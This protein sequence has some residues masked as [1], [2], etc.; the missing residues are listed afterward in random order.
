M[1]PIFSPGGASIAYTAALRWAW[2]VPVMGGTPHP[3]FPD[4]S[5][6]TWMDN[7]R[8][9]FS[10]I[11]SGRHMG[12]VEATEGRGDERYLYLPK[13]EGGMVHRSSL[14][15]HGRWRLLAEMD[16]VHGW[17]PR[18]LVPF[19]RTSSGKPIG[20][21]SAHCTSVAWSPGG[22]W[23]YFSSDAGGSFHIWRQHIPEGNSE[24]V[25]FGL[26]A[27]RRHRHGS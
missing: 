13:D 2:E 23:M 27:G 20:V 25:T 1:S 18:R 16:S 21:P 4:A 26:D 22:R 11:Q 7:G 9:L 14:S 8:V 12:L 19:D 6:L 10:K 3:M 17:L 5:G 24:Q 15:P